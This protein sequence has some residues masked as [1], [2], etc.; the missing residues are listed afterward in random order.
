MSATAAGPAR[1]FRP[2][3]GWVP[4]GPPL[5]PCGD[6]DLHDLR[7]DDLRRDYWVIPASI[8]ARDGDVLICRERA[9]RLDGRCSHAHHAW[10]SLADHAYARYLDA[11]EWLATVEVWG[12]T[13]VQGD[14]RG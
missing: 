10:R 4:V 8:S 12:V 6:D 5:P 14:P 7:R 3:Q 9:W 1:L 2:S 11:A 13:R